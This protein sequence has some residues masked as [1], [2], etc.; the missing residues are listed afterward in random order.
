MEINF[1]KFFPE[2]F[3]WK[4]PF[5][6]G[7]NKKKS[8]LAKTPSLHEQSGGT[9]LSM[10]ITGT[11]SRDSLISWLTYLEK[12]CPNLSGVPVVFRIRTPERGLKVVEDESDRKAALDAI[13][14]C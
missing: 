6:K 3:D 5:I 11:G 14:N 9:I 7:S 12:E 8:H 1:W 10:C 13:E 2:L 4:S